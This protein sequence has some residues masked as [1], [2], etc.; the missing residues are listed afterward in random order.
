MSVSKRFWGLSSGVLVAVWQVSALA[1]PA[2]ED[3]LPKTFAEGFMQGV[4]LP[5]ISIYHLAAMIGIGILVGIAARGIVPVLAFGLAAIVGVAIQLSPFD[6]PG[7][8]A[9]VAL[10]TMVIGVLILLRQPLSPKVASIVFA[11]AGLVHGYSLGSVLVGADAVPILAYVAGLLVAQTALGV[12]SCA[13]TLG[14]T[15]WPA[16]RT[17]LMIAG[18]LVMVAGGVAAIEAAGLIG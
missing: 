10:T 17:A 5:V 15:K 2:V 1:Q 18:C 6:I 13:I 3:E 14:A 4:G 12:A 11:V 9:F 16:Q 7:E 8:G